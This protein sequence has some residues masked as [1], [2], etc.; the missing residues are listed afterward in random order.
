MAPEGAA[1][2]PLSPGYRAKKHQNQDQILVLR[3]TL[4]NQ[5]A[6]NYDNK[7]VEFGSARVYAAHHQFGSN[8]S[9]GRGSGVPA[10]PFL[11]V[12][13]QDAK[14]LLDSAKDVLQIELSKIK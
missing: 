10:R 9:S 1:W 11:G 8:K 3:G 12:N 4:R 6:Y 2:K 7:R 13:Q 5:L 14:R